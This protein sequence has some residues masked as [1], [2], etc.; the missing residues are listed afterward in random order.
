MPEMP[1]VETV[2][3]GLAPLVESALIRKPLLYYPGAVKHPSAGEF[4]R[5]LDGQKIAGTGRKGKYLLFYLGAGDTL[6]VHLGMTGALVAGFPS[7]PELGGG[8]HLRA[9]FPLDNDCTLY[10]SDPRK[11]GKLWLLKK[12][13]TLDCLYRLGPD[14]WEEA[15][16]L[17]LEEKLAGRK[18]SRLKPLLLDQSFLSGLGNIYVDESLYRAGLHPERRTGTL[19]A[20]EVDK[21]Y[22]AVRN[23]L[24]EGLDSGGTSTQNYRNARGEPGNFQDKLSVYRREGYRCRRCGAV[25]ERCVVAG[26]G[27]YCCPSC[28]P[29]A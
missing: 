15:T 29:I 9:V 2:R 22:R 3:R 20:E 6:V 19:T 16:P 17:L 7:D 27:T 14:W 28:Q 5:G 10:F 24:R 4:T 23:T 1:E 8:K 26:R 21:L 12:E 11:F 13:E 18:K 25:I